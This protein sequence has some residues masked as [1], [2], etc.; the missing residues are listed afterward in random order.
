MN[1]SIKNFIPIPEDF[2]VLTRVAGQGELQGFFQHETGY[3]LLLAG[4]ADSNSA[5]YRSIRNAAYCLIRKILFF[6]NCAARLVKNSCY[7]LYV[8]MEKQIRIV[9]FAL[10]AGIL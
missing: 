3:D 1:M 2:I 7:Q 10:P 6:K 5:L 8:K 9:I 4:F